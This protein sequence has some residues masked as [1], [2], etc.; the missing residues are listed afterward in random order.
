MLSQIHPKNEANFNVK[1]RFNFNQSKFDIPIFLYSIFPFFHYS[2]NPIFHSFNCRPDSYRGPN[3]Q[4]VELF[5]HSTIPIF[6][7]PNCP[8]IKLSHSSI[9]PSFHSSNCRIVELPNCRILP[10]F[11]PSILPNGARIAAFCNPPYKIGNR[12]D[13]FSVS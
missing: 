2:N 3:Y 10:P 1:R 5:H 13:R 11:P 12:A 8:I 6:Q 4:I 7:L 9:L